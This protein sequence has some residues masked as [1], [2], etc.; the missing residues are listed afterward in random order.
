MQTSSEF[1]KSVNKGETSLTRSEASFL[2]HEQMVLLNKTESDVSFAPGGINYDNMDKLNELTPVVQRSTCSFAGE[3]DSTFNQN[4][5]NESRASLKANSTR[6]FNGS[7]MMANQTMENYCNQSSI[8]R[9]NQLVMQSVERVKRTAM[10]YKSDDF[11][12]NLNSHKPIGNNLINTLN[13][14]KVIAD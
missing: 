5:F 9:I 13:P 3:A 6:D 12:A 2:A 7:L 14:F 4:E 10:T 1:S 11:L 8:D